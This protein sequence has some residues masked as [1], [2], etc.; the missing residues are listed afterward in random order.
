MDIQNIVNHLSTYENIDHVYL[1]DIKNNNFNYQ[2]PA[3]YCLI[4]YKLNTYRGY[5]DGQVLSRN[6]NLVKSFRYLEWRYSNFFNSFRTLSGDKEISLDEDFDRSFQCMQKEAL[7]YNAKEIVFRVATKQRNKVIN[8]SYIICEL[9]HSEEHIIERK[10]E[11]YIYQKMQIEHYN[12]ALNWIDKKDSEVY[13]SHADHC[14]E[15]KQ[16]HSEKAK[17]LGKQLGIHVFGI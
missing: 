3:R 2:R 4:S 6:G 14:K 8:Y 9:P 13:Q 5:L 12:K 15:A 1:S 17:K 7:K 10:K 16:I 11:Q